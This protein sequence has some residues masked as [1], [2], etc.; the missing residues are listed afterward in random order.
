MLVKYQLEQPLGAILK[1][2]WLYDENAKLGNQGGGVV[3]AKSR[4][5]LKREVSDA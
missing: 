5:V 1:V 4:K 2:T 3:H